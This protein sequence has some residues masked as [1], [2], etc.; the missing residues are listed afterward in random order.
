[1]ANQRSGAL[2]TRITFDIID[3]GGSA[4]VNPAESRCHGSSASDLKRW[5]THGNTARKGLPNL[6]YSKPKKHYQ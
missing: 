2:G 6:T 1:L 4:Q 5:A 3:I